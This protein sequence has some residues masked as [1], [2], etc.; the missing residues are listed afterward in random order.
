M[1]R[2]KLLDNDSMILVAGLM[3][4]SS[5]GTLLVNDSSLRKWWS[6]IDL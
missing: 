6:L 3:Y 1:L 5:N 4:Q 2:R